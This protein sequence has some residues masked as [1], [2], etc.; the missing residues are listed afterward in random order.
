MTP[1]E[2]ASIRALLVLLRGAERHLLESQMKSGRSVHERRLL[3][4]EALE[5]REAIRSI[6]LLERK[7]ES[8]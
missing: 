3:E 5:I 1:A 6:T 4:E 7:Y 8:E 2:R